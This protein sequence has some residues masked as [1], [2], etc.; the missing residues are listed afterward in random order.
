MVI[1][2]TGNQNHL[3]SRL[4]PDRRQAQPSGQGRPG[5]GGMWAYMVRTAEGMVNGFRQAISDRQSRIATDLIRR[6]GGLV[7]ETIL[8]T[9]Y[10]NDTELR[11]LYDA[12]VCWTTH[13]RSPTG[14]GV[15]DSDK[16]DGQRPGPHVRHRPRRHHM[17]FKCPQCQL[18]RRLTTVRTGKFGFGIKQPVDAQPHRTAPSPTISKSFPWISAVASGR[19]IR[20][21]RRQQGAGRSQDG[22][23]AA[24]WRR[25]SL[26]VVAPIKLIECH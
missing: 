13:S 21:D 4:I 19:Q 1:G 12:L 7:N 15:C 2:G 26:R 22:P 23:W 8:M 14:G 20:H 16:G 24:S 25:V 5:G 10:D 18:P 9:V 6:S 11:S 17:G 3:A